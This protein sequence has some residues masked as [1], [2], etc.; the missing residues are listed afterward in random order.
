[1][2]PYACELEHCVH[3]PAGCFSSACPSV[4]VHASVSTC[5]FVSSQGQVLHAH[6]YLCECLDV[7]K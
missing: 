2:H 1:M 7:H 4:D 3:I 6:L 5:L